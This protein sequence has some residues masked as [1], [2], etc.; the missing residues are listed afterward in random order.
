MNW[1]RGFSAAFRFL[2]IFSLPGNFGTTRDDLVHAA[3]FFPL[4]GL[5]LGGLAVF[6]CWCF[7]LILPPIPVAVLGVGVL[8]FFSGA[9]HLDGLADAADGFFSARP[10]DQALEIMRDSRI[11][12]M[13]VVA[14]LFVILL[15]IACLT[16]LDPIL[17]GKAILLMPFAGRVSLVVLMAIL[18]YARSGTGLGDMF[19]SDKMKIIALVWLLFFTGIVCLLVGLQGLITVGFILIMLFAYA[20][21]CKK[22]ISGATGDTLGAGC[23]LAETFM[24]LGLCLIS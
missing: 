15:K 7:S 24:V 21:Y 4:V 3:P 20:G 14:L 5:L 13:G 12:A 6:C 11:G 8:A 19:Y 23:E 16:S 2:T 1:I 18:P 10:K 22:K 17:A 9:L